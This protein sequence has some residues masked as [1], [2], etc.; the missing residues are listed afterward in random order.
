MLRFLLSLILTLSTTYAYGGGLDFLHLDELAESLSFNGFS[1][2]TLVSE[3]C[4]LNLRSTSSFY[5]FRGSRFYP[6]TINIPT[7]VANELTKRGY[8]LINQ[9]PRRGDM[10]LVIDLNYRDHDRREGRNCG[11]SE[12]TGSIALYDINA[13][14]RGMI[15]SDSVTKNH[16]IPHKYQSCFYDTTILLKALYKKMPRCQR[17]DRTLLEEAQRRIQQRQSHQDHMGDSR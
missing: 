3:T 1:S 2:D 8:R 14:G 12:G 13:S 9:S 7:S 5:D 16:D 15:F 4:N 6:R 10:E 17:L 11:R